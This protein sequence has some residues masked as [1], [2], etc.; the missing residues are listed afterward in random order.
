MVINSKLGFEEHLNEN[1]EEKTGKVRVEELLNQLAASFKY[2][3]NRM[4]SE[5]GREILEVV[6]NLEEENERLKNSKDESVIAEDKVT[7]ICYDEHTVMEREE[8]K[9]FYL[10]AIHNSDGAEQKRYMN[11]YTDLCNGESLCMDE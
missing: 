7:I 5:V 9:A 1:I 3:Q 11:I 10:E 4:I 8:A 2:P 6:E